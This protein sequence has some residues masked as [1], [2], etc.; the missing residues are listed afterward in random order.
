MKIKIENSTFPFYCIS[1]SVRKFGAEVPPEVQEPHF[2]EQNFNAV[3]SRRFSPGGRTLIIGVFVDRCRRAALGLGVV[4][5]GVGVLRV[6]SGR[7]LF[8]S[9]E[10]FIHL[11]P[12]KG[13]E[14]TLG[15]LFLAPDE[16][17]DSGGAPRR[18]QT[19][20]PRPRRS[21]GQRLLPRLRSAASITLSYF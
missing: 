16:C 14:E 2:G 5:V 17:F 8:F 13:R 6:T 18:L 21:I 19:A 20:A 7:L 4:G 11:R 12:L 9:I 10:K 1:K 15:S 3:F